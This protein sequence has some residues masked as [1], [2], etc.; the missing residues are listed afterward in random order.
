MHEVDT[1]KV[2]DVH[3]LAVEALGEG[4][5]FESDGVGG[6]KAAA[7]VEQHFDGSFV[8]V[9]LWFDEVDWRA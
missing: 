8:E 6:T 2:R 7:F 4:V 1:G 5:T 9:G 3:M